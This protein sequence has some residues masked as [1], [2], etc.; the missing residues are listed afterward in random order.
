M[1]THTLVA[2]SPDDAV[3]ITLNNKRIINSEV[4]WP[5]E[6]QTAEIVLKYTKYES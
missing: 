4:W 2:S 5:L 1:C 3:I 6:G